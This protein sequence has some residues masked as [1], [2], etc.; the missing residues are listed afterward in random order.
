MLAVSQV[1]YFS[2]IGKRKYHE[3]VIITATACK[4]EY[5]ESKKRKRDQHNQ[6]GV[7]RK[8]IAY[9]DRDVTKRQRVEEKCLIHE[10]KYICAIYEC[11]GVTELDKSDYMPYIY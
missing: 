10:E 5:R 2:N 11:G 8:F 4:K 3:S 6:H 7:K 9:S 1:N